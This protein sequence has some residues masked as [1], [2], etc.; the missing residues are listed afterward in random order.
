M[1]FGEIFGKTWKDYKDNFRSIFMFMVIFLGILWLIS[2]S[3][4][5]FWV[6]SNET[7]RELSLNPQ[8]INAGSKFPLQYLITTWVLGII[9]VLL[10]FFINAGLTGISIKKSKFHFNEIVKVGSSSYFKYIALVVVEFIFLVGLFLLLIIPGIIFLIYWTFGIYVLYD[11]K[12]GIL[13]SLKRSREIVRGNWWK[14]FGYF[15]LLFLIGTIISIIISIISS[16]TQIIYS[17]KL[18]NAEPISLNFMIFNVFLSGISN[19]LTNL[20]YMPFLILFLK[21]FYFDLKKKKKGLKKK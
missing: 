13:E 14:V 21:N 12:K 17:I 11:E 18:L 6:F 15:I 16:P 10:Y 9:G 8:L 20:I 19:F 1:G 4:L 5:L 7:V 3:N 2:F